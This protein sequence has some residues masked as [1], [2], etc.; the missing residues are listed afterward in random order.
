MN[1]NG[2][3]GDSLVMMASFLLIIINKQN[4]VF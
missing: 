2:R 3:S 1:D 4:N